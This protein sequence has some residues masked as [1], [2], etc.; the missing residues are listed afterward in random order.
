MNWKKRFVS[1]K[2]NVKFTLVIILFMVI[3][4]GIL[5][6]ILFYNMEKNVVSENT[7]Y[8]EY[9]MERNKDAVATKINSINMSTQ[10]FLSDEPLLEMLKRTKDGETFS[11]EEWYSFKNSD[12]VSLERLVNNNPLLYGVRV[13]ASND[14]VQEMM[15]ILYAA[16][17][18]EKQPWQ[19]EETV[20]GW[21][22]DF[23]DQ[24][25][26]SY[27][28][29]QNREIL[30][31]VT[32]IK[33][34]DSGTLG[35]IEAAMTMENMFPSLYENIED[36]WSCFL[37]E[38]GGCYFGEGDGEDENTGR[39]E[40]LAEIM[41][42]YTADE[43]IQ[44]DPALREKYYVQHSSRIPHAQHVCGGHARVFGCSDIFYQ[45]DRKT[46][47]KTAVR[48]SARH[49]ARAGRRSG[50]GDRALRTG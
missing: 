12:I 44:R 47:V 4:I 32:E 8:M 33:D 9:T 20:T 6:G 7:G 40:L 2:L 11:A 22:Y 50:R 24:I 30:S 49:P 42:Q 35:M 31:L 1:Q 45:C 18:M 23:N 46:S 37:T 34:S 39:Q 10:F 25:F 17:R 16:S 5:A 28:M 36:E 14:R 43:E 27:T 15:P 13:Y 29:R 38:D 3:P 21:H 19:S 48:D 41:A 26:N